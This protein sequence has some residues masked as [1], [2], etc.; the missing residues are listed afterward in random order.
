MEVD[1]EVEAAGAQP[2]R[3]LKVITNALEAARSIDDDNFI[4]GGVMPNDWFRRGLDEI[5][6]AGL[7]KAPP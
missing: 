5:G 3:Q 4:K 6:D 7:W 1:D 2:A